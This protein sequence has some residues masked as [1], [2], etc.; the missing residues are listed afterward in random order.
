MFVTEDTSGLVT[1]ESKKKEMLTKKGELRAYGDD[2]TL[3]KKLILYL[4][5]IIR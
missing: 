3:V 4:S 1:I 5:A 2:T